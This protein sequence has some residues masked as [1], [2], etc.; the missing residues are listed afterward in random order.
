MIAAIDIGSTKT[1]V[2]L[3]DQ[4]P[5]PVAQQKFPTDSDYRQLVKQTSDTIR[6]L[7]AGLVL[8]AIIIASRG[9]INYQKLTITDHKR[10]GWDKAPV[11]KLL[12][13]DFKVPVSVHHDTTMAALAEAGLGAG[14]N[15]ASMLYV[16]ISTG[17]GT[18]LALNG[19]VVPPFDHS[20]GG[21]MVVG[22]SSLSEEADKSTFE[23][24][25]SGE[26]IKERWGKY[27]WD[28]HDEAVWKAYA[29]ELA[30]GLNNM[31]VLIQPSMVVL[32]GGVAVHF[33]K[34]APFLK[35]ALAAHNTSV[36]P[37][38]P[39]KQARWVETAV[40]Y[41]CFVWHQDQRTASRA[42]G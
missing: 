42:K 37:I 1:L 34:F 32:G 16:T 25:V 20:G 4:E 36:F 38:P 19:Q 6:E 12:A 26:A 28:I 22:L 11:G 35:Q 14:K 33:D 13:T 21:D 40:V 23:Q 2:A 9:E 17:I 24:K 30:L 7:A 29:E 31:I 8:E 15:S 27:G 10:L 41:G 3:F 18:A 5:K 39:I